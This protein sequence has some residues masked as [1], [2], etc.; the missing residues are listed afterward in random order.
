MLAVLGG[1][2]DGVHYLLEKGA[3]PDAK[4]KR[5]S[6]ALHR[7]VG[8]KLCMWLHSLAVPQ[9]LKLVFASLARLNVKNKVCDTKLHTCYRQ[10]KYFIFHLTSKYSTYFVCSSKMHLQNKTNV[11]C[12]CFQL[13]T[14]ISEQKALATEKT[15][16]LTTFSPATTNYRF[17]LR[18]LPEKILREL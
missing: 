11:N 18:I 17:F 6:T 14:E 15:T 12:N 2:T 9:N 8:Q 1:H 7:G 3:L 4:D 13:L 16:W 10:P 5:G